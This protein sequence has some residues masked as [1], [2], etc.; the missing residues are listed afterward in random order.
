MIEIGASAVV[1]WELS[2]TGEH[3]QRVA[4]K[5][6]GG[7]FI[8]LA[9]YLLIQSGV[10]L[11]LAHHAAPSPGGI[12]WTAVTAAVMFALAAGKA[13]TGKALGNPVL[14]AEGRVTFIDGLLA[15]AVLTGVLLNDLAGWW[16]ADPVAG[17]VI[18]YY[19][20]REAVEILR[21]HQ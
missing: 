2:G 3:R 11:A 6:I 8:V 12:G 15:T 16:W 21:P 18:V 4:L 20:I 7:A 17:L 10:A 1:I 14:T 13:H 9:L 19:A 5:L